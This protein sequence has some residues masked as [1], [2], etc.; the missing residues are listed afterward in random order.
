MHSIATSDSEYSPLLEGEAS[1]APTF[2]DRGACRMRLPSLHS[3]PR[4][5]WFYRIQL[6]P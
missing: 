3:D 6:V 4:R 1:P 5:L 2:G